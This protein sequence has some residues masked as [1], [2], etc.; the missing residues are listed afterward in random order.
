[1]R[2]R[3]AVKHVVERWNRDDVSPEITEARAA[4]LKAMQEADAGW[5]RASI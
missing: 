5:Q 2:A 3:E 4:L 1:V